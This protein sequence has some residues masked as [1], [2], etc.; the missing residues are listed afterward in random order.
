MRLYRDYI[1]DLCGTLVDIRTNE[2][3][4]MLWNK[5]SLFYGY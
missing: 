1:F 2:K 3:Q 4:Q 5:M